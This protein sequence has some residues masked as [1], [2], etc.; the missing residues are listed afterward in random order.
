MK[1]VLH[2]RDGLAETGV[3]LHVSLCDLGVAN[4]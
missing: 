3:G 1:M 4:R 2:V